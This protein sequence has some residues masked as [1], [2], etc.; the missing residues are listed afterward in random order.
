MEITDIQIKKVEG[1]GKLKAYASLTFDDIFVVHNIRIVEGDKGLFIG[2]PSR[3]TK[4]GEFKDVAHPIKQ[5][6][7]K[8]LEDSI[9]TAFGKVS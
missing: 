6:F 8:K 1:E 9:I 7:R 4:T 3:K 2:M 5:E